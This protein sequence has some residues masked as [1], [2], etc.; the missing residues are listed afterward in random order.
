MYK[1]SWISDRIAKLL[2]KEAENVAFFKGARQALIKK[3]TID[4]TNAGTKE[5]NLSGN[6]IYAQASSSASANCDIQFSRRDDDFEKYNFIEGFGLKHPFDKIYVSW[7]AQDGE[8]ITL[9]VGEVYPE[10]F[11]IIDNRAIT[12][13]TQVYDS[14][15]NLRQNVRSLNGDTGTQILKS[16]YGTT[17]SETIHTV[18]AGKNFYLTSANICGKGTDI[19]FMFSIIVTNA[20]DVQQYRVLSI[21]VKG[22]AASGDG[23]GDSTSNSFPMPLKIPAGYK[24][25]LVTT[26][27]GAPS[28]SEVYANIQGW[29]E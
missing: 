5:L 8:T 24:I 25:K 2:R 11:D 14:I 23:P 6:F 9:W 15:Y 26:A 18:T 12:K 13:L 19:G 16:A 4:L 7:S 3:F 10:L 21:L 29:E 1:I 22:E 20:A 27:L 17:T 28:T